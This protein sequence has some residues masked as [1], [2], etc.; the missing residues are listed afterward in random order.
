MLFDNYCIRCGNKSFQFAEIEFYYYKKKELNI[1][2]FDDEW[3]KET[4]PRNKNAGD[5]FFHYSGVDVCF[6]CEFEEKEKNNEY[7][8][9]GGILVRSILDGN[10]ILAGPLFCANAILN[11]CEKEMPKLEPLEPNMYHKCKYERDTRC[12]ISSDEKQEK[13]KELYLCYYVTHVN[14]VELKWNEASER[15]A[16][17]KTNGCF[18]TKTRNYQRERPLK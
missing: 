12:G 1:S 8:E 2:N 5:F 18:K 9:Y 14:T 11:A 15:I 4:Y 10:K 3:N 7:G 6:Q 16:W 17:D 13:G